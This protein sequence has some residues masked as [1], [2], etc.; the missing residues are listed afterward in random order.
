MQPTATV[1]TVFISCDHHIPFTTNMAASCN[2]VSVD[3][4][5]LLLPPTTVATHR[6]WP[7]AGSVGITPLHLAAQRGGVY[8]CRALLSAGANVTVKD[9]RDLTVLDAA[10][11]GGDGATVAELLAAPLGWPANEPRPANLLLAAVRRGG[12]PGLDV[13]RSLLMLRSPGGEGGAEERA[14]LLGLEGEAKIPEGSLTPLLAAARA[15]DHRMAQVLV[16]AGARC[17]GRTKAGKGLADLAPSHGDARAAL[18][19]LCPGV[20]WPGPEPAEPAGGMTGELRAAVS[21]A[22]WA[23]LQESGWA[24]RPDWAAGLWGLVTDGPA[25]LRA[26]TGLRLGDQKKLA[27]FLKSGRAKHGGGGG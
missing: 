24:S 23:A 8:A 9:T 7:F 16:A 3:H 18:I 27:A 19:E 4:L 17:D 12:R 6:P 2:L 10:V 5:L 13:V 11:A 15:G 25:E 22:G 20:S 14:R 26:G 21:A 1:I